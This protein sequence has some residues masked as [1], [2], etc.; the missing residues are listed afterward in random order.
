MKIKFKPGHHG[1]KWAAHVPLGGK[2][3]TDAHAHFHIEATE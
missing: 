3:R 1:A 2:R